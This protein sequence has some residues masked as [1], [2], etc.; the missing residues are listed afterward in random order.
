MESVGNEGWDSPSVEE[1]G[2]EI[3]L[4]S[5]EGLTLYPRL[6]RYSGMETEDVLEAEKKAEPTLLESL[7]SKLKS[8][9]KPKDVQGGESGVMKQQADINIFTVASGLLYEVRNFRCST[10]I[11]TESEP[12]SAFRI[13]HDFECPS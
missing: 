8:I 11:Y 6:A 7:A 3:T 1:G 5:F 13:Y 10:F 4:V 12:N 9:F 2:D